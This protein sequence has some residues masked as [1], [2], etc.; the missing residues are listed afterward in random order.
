MYLLILSNDRGQ[1]T[2][3][4]VNTDLF[5]LICDHYIVISRTRNQPNW[6]VPRLLCRLTTFRTPTIP[7]LPYNITVI[8]VYHYQLS[9]IRYTSFFSMLCTSKYVPLLIFNIF[10]QLLC[11][12]IGLLFYLY[13]TQPIL[14]WVHF[15]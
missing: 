3:D 7:R 2:A 15:K 8:A 1:S 9:V 6:V 4:L 11:D 13:R 12:T 10:F 14:F 5:R